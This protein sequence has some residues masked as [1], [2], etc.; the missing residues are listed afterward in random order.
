[1]L[2][3]AGQQLEQRGLPRRGRPQQQREAAGRQQAADVVQNDQPLFLRAQQPQPQEAP[4][5]AGMVARTPSVSSMRVVPYPCDAFHTQTIHLNY[6][7][8]FPTA[9]HDHDLHVP[10]AHVF[11]WDVHP[12]FSPNG[13]VPCIRPHGAL[14]KRTEADCQ[15][16]LCSPRLE[17]RLASTSMRTSTLLRSMLY[18]AAGFS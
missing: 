10:D 14:T 15:K 4:L 5:R 12:P 11:L 9:V 6:I 1:M 8:I 3:L 13:Y 7:H 16:L 2:Q 18:S 17:R